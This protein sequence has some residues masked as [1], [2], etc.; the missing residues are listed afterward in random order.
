MSGIDKLK[1]IREDHLNEIDFHK[2]KMTEISKDIIEK[3]KKEDALFE[4]I[5]N[6]WLEYA[7]K[8]DFGW[9]HHIEVDGKDIWSFID[10]GE[11]QRGRTYT[12]D[13]IVDYIFD[14]VEYEEDMTEERAWEYCKKLMEDNVGSMPF[15]W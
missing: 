8:K 5:F 10:H 13:E 12:I 7:T 11:P 3:M 4:D 9:L 1:E 15:D 14:R 6:E 2:E